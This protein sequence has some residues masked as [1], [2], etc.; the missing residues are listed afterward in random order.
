MKRVLP[1]LFLLL[2]LISAV[3]AGEP[4]KPGPAEAAHAFL[5][6]LWDDI[7]PRVTGS[8]GNAAALDRVEAE[9]RAMGYAPKRDRFTM[10]GWRRGEDRAD[11]IAPF[12]RRLRIAALGYSQAHP[13]F[14]SEVVNVGNGRPQDYPAGDLK[15]RIGLLGQG[16]PL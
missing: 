11:M 3:G 13:A 15:G 9:L 6:R 8:A 5:Q 12:P 10:P 1:I 14:E 16:S 2:P 4:A 7:G